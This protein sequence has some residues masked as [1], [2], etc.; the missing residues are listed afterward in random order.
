MNIV[1]N[2]REIT[3][4]NLTKTLWPR[5]GYTKY[6]LLQ[7]YI[8]VSPYLLPF[9]QDR[10]LSVTRFPHGV[11]KAGFY[12]KN[13]PSYAPP[14]VSTFPW[15]H[16]VKGEV[17]RYTIVNNLET[18]VWL[19]NQGCIEF[20]PWASRV[21]APNFP[22]FAIFDLDPM[23]PTG[24][25]AAVAVAEQ[26]KAILDHF[27]L[28]AYVK[29]SGA[30]GLHIYLPVV[31]KFTYRQIQ[32]F[33]RGIGLLVQRLMPHQIAI[34]ERRIKDRQGRVYI[35][36]LQNARGQTIAAPYS[37]RPRP[38][39]P[40]AMPVMWQELRHISPGDFT[41]GTIRQHLARQ[42]DLFTSLFATPQD[43]TSLLAWLEAVE[44]EKGLSVSI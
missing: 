20:H 32:R 28:T 19:V 41:M 2:G 18:L 39:A 44:Q 36:Y 34:D 3:L 42:G 35:D 43:I 5:E 31:R 14:W 40:V 9:L 26:I 7:Y 16:G 11:T 22:D 12:Q 38:Q 1:I 29:T 6:D 24:F 4:T 13:T 15:P 27:N 33:V 8:N 23:P 10:P 37:L 17:T 30:T 21:D 25:A